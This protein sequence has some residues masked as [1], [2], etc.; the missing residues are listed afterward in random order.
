MRFPKVLIFSPTY[1]GKEYCRERF[2][3][4]VNKIQYPNKEFIMIDNSTSEDYFNLLKKEGVN[5]HR[6]PRGNNSRE[7]LSNA[8]NYAR[9]YAIENDFDY[10]LSVESDLFPPRD[11]IFKL[12]KHAKPVVGALYMLGGYYDP[13][14]EKQFPTVPCVFVP[15]KDGTGGTRFVSKDEHKMMLEMGGIHQVHGMGVGCTLIDIS[16]VKKYPFWCDSRFDNKHSDVYFYM[17]L[18]NDKVP[19]YV[20]YDNEVEH[21]PSPWSIVDDK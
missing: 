21:Q 15:K 16:V 8:Q 17:T 19:V 20:D 10:V 5:V 2:V 9:R 18:W 1:E 11:I 12:M 3:D 14:S 7:A 13:K 4:T 6:V